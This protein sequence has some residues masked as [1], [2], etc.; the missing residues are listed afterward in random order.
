MKLDINNELESFEVLKALIERRKEC[1]K[2]ND[3]NAVESLNSLI[4]QFENTP[5]YNVL[6]ED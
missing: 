3:R 6:I 2:F 4:E 1:K 5:A